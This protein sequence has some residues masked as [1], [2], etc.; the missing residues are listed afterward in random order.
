MLQDGTIEPEEFST[1]LQKELRSSP[2]P[3]LI[4]FLKVNLI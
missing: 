4:H 3:Y 1:Q 2:Q